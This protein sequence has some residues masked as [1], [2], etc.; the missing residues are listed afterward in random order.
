V[1]CRDD[2]ATDNAAEMKAADKLHDAL[3]GRYSCG[4]P[5]HHA[6]DH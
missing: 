4:R 2:G 5:P 1:P 3:V 6:Y